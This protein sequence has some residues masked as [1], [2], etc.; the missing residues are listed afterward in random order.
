M[1]GCW[2]AR[3]ARLLSRPART[4]S[5]LLAQPLAAA[6]SMRQSE[7]A[8][9]QPMCAELRQHRRLALSELAAAPCAT[10]AGQQHMRR[11]AAYPL[12]LSLPPVAAACT[13]G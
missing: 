13:A 2:M 3:C 6:Q 11:S 5:L 4:T 10:A 7:G 12:Q 8:A 1:R 9:Q